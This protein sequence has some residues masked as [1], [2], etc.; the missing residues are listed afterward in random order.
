MAEIGDCPQFKPGAFAR[1][2]L[3]ARMAA[4]LT[5]LFAPLFLA[6]CFNNNATFRYRLTLTY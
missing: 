1:R 4:A 6:G 2:G 3:A 5:V